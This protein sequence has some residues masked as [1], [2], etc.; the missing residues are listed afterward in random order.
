MQRISLVFLAVVIALLGCGG[1]KPRA[2]DPASSTDTVIKTEAATLKSLYKLLLDVNELAVPKKFYERSYVIDLA[3]TIRGET[4]HDWLV[5][6]HHIVNPP[7]APGQIAR[8][9]EV[10]KLEVQI[11]LRQSI[12]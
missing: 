11:Q 7:A 5:P 2:G 6:C 8:I 10:L 1:D 4:P 12:S 3:G 9:K